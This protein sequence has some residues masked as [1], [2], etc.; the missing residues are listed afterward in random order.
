MLCLHVSL[1][2]DATYCTTETL[3]LSHWFPPIMYPSISNRASIVMIL[4]SMRI[5]LF[6]CISSLDQHC[7]QPP[8]EATIMYHHL[9]MYWSTPMFWAFIPLFI[10]LKL[11]WAGICPPHPYTCHALYVSHPFFR[12]HNKKPKATIVRTRKLHFSVGLSSCSTIVTIIPMILW[13]PSTIRWAPSLT[14][15]GEIC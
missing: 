15:Q 12:T 9:Y 13:C 11:L 2:L 1:V 5:P 4:H 3:T 14:H 8:I 7:I 6:L 10:L